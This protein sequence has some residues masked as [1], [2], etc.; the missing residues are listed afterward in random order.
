MAEVVLITCP[1][2]GNNLRIPSS[3]AEKPMRCK[4]C[5]Q[6]F[7]ARRKAVPSAATVPFVRPHAANGQDATTPRAT[8]APIKA[9]IAPTPKRGGV[10][11]KGVLVGCLVLAVVGMTAVVAIGIV[12]AAL[13]TMLRPDP[14]APS[15]K[16]PVVAV[17][18]APVDGEPKTDPVGPV[19]TPPNT[20]EPQDT[21]GGEKDKSPPDSNKGPGDKKQP[22]K[23]KADKGKD[24][25]GKKDKGPPDS[26]KNPPTSPIALGILNELAMFPPTTGGKAAPLDPASLPE[27][28]AN[29]LDNYKA[30]YMSMLDFAN[31]EAKFPL[32]AGVVKA[33]T[34]LKD[35]A[36]FKVR[37]TLP[38]NMKDKELLV[39]KKQV[40]NEQDSLALKAA[41]L[42]DMVK[43]LEELGDRQ[44]ERATRRWQ[45]HYDYTMLRLKARVVY[46]VEYNFNL[47]KIRTDSLVALEPD[48]K[49]Y[50]LTAQDKVT[51][52]EAYIKQYVKDLK[53]GWTDLTKN[54][55]DTP[56]AF[57]ATREQAV[58]LGLSWQPA[59]N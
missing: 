57:M 11:W 53:K 4:F 46:M 21:K 58:M 35:N 59:K 26:S 3:W 44:R 14:S 23:G 1:H 37:Q 54:H 51:T 43:E 10:P 49:L 22:D 24:Q 50:R 20:K 5:K 40:I 38:G 18:Q 55:A 19:K 34:A 33:I 17:A 30:D 6:V 12:G 47:A 9:A 16:D 31:Q 8:P 48:D 41:V 52:N 15:K 29:V 27:F 25:P 2:C 13:M 32:R 45:A 56:W 7:Q 28:P 42:K 39:L 36:F